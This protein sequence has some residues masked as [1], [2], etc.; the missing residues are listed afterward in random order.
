MNNDLITNNTLQEEETLN[1]KKEVAYYGFFWPW[2]VGAILFTISSAFLYLRYSNTVYVST[3]QIQIKTDTDATSF[4]TG[5][6]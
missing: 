6:L 2:F 5:D 3:A 4:L 1:L